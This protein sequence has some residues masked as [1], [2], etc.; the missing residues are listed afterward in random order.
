MSENYYA[1]RSF[2]KLC[3]GELVMQKQNYNFKMKEDVFIY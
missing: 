2:N 1:N 3:L